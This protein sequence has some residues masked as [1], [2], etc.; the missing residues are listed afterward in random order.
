VRISA[1][2]ALLVVCFVPLLFLGSAAGA[3]RADGCPPTTCG[4]TSAQPSGSGLVF[5]R[6]NGQQGDLV[7]YDAATGARRFELASGLL[8]ADGTRYVIARGNWLSLWDVTS[9]ARRLGRWRFPH[10]VSAYVISAD[11][12]RI[13][14]QVATTR[15]TSRFA[16]FDA[17]RGRI[18]RSVTLRGPDQ[19][20]ALSLD[21]TKLFFI[22]W[23]STTY[24]LQTYD[25]ATH[26]LHATRLAEPDEKMHGTAWAAIATRDGRWLLTLYLGGGENGTFVHALDL[27]TGIAHCIDLPWHFNNPSDAGAAALS[28]SP[29]GRKLYIA[30]PLLGR[31]TTVDLVEV[32]VTRD[33]RFHPLED[34]RF[35]YGVGPA[36]AVSPRGRVLA[37][38]AAG[39]LWRYDTAYGVVHAPTVVARRLPVASAVP[40]GVAGVGFT[41]DGRRTLALFPGGGHVSLDSA[42][43]RVLGARTPPELFPIRAGVT[44]ELEA[45]DASGGP[46]FVLPFGRESAD[47]S[48]YFSAL[49]RYGTTTTM[50][51]TYDPHSGRILAGHVLQG[52]WQLG[53]VSPSARAIALARHARRNTH[54][55]IV[56]R[57]GRTIRDRTLRGD[58]SLD[59]VNDDAQTLFL[60]QHYRAGHYAV[61]ALSFRTGRIRTATLREKGKAEEPVMTGQAAGQVA[62]HDGRWLLTLYLNTKEHKAFVHALDLHRAAAVCIDLPAAGH[63]MRELRDYS[64]SL[65][66]DGDVYAANG[67]LGVVARVDLRKQNVTETVRFSSPRTESFSPASALSRDGRLLYFASGRSVWRFDTVSD[68]L[69]GPKL[70]VAPVLGLAF[71]RDGRKVFAA[72]VDGGVTTLAA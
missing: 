47:G 41:P 13:V 69:R 43:G 32:R 68:E 6:P 60:I 24:D 63:P 50:L 4:T 25:F 45:Y 40:P 37:F 14:L 16:V 9:N 23:R 31:V 54:V 58:Y 46:R 1:V 8:S 22:H 42:S 35:T 72:R 44:G 67:T 71:S 33:V 61:K 56:D 12:Y 38:A 15:R 65:A 10:R 53:A 21:A 66:P 51:R 57:S 64:L 34:S 59:A 11:G 55:L 7:A 39:D 3:A 48:R 26:K 17:A 28:L 49:P 20:E 2:R 30:N 5:V 27:R 52:R 19:P 70:A 62:S 36:A 29:D 18:L